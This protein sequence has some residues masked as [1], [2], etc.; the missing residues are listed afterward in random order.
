VAPRRSDLDRHRQLGISPVLRR[1]MKAPQMTVQYWQK[2]QKR[3]ALAM[4]AVA[5]TVSL[6]LAT[7]ARAAAGWQT[8]SSFNVPTGEVNLQYSYNCPKTFPIAH[9]GSFAMNGTGQSS[10]VFLTYSG[11]RIDIPSY[12]EWA[13]HFYWPGGAPAGITILFN[14]Y[15]AKK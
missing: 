11:T 4:C 1:N 10:Q 14:G 7:P 12:S 3:Y 6:G 15:C 9:S 2:T 8:I 5:G 13:W